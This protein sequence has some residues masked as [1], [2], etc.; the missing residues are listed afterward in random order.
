TSFARTLSMIGEMRVEAL[1]SEEP[2]RQNARRSLVANRDIPAGKTIDKDDLTWKRPAG[3]IS[4]RNYYEV[5][6]KVARA[7]IEEDT[8]LQWSHLE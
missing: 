6:G 7:A 8:V 2:A 5:L 3:G 4:P 1:A